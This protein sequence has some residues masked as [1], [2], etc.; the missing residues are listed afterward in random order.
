MCWEVVSPVLGTPGKGSQNVAGKMVTSGVE[1][2]VKHGLLFRPVEGIQLERIVL[3]GFR[4]A[5]KSRMARQLEARLGWRSLSTDELIESRINQSIRDFVA[6]RGWSAFRKVESEVVTQVCRLKNVIIDTGGGVVER[7]MNMKKLLPNALVVW[8]D[9]PEAELI[10]R[11]SKS[12]DRPLL[13][14]TD[15]KADVLQNYRRRAPLYRKYA[16]LYVNTAKPE[17]KAYVME[18]ISNLGLQ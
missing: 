14:E 18:F 13:S 17:T 15:W 3:I 4:G 2:L 7:K 12:N 5:G 8:V 1:I 11:L 10:E 16:H 9:A 6:A